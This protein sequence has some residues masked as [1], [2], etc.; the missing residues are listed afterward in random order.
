MSGKWRSGEATA[1]NREEVEGGGEIPGDSSVVNQLLVS[2]LLY[3]LHLPHRAV[4]LVQ[5]SAGDLH[6]LQP[7]QRLSSPWKRSSTKCE[8][9]S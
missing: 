8:S 6:I 3:I 5:S 4:Y 1:L 7:L 9:R 2:G